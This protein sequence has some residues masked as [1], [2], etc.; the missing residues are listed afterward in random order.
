MST[1]S[2][3]TTTSTTSTSISLGSQEPLK[4]DSSF[5]NNFHRSYKMPASMKLPYTPSSLKSCYSMTDS[6]SSLASLMIARK[7]I[8]HRMNVRFAMATELPALSRQVSH[9]SDELLI[10]NTNNN[11]DRKRSQEQ[12]K[13]DYGYDEPTS[14]NGASS[15]QEPPFKRR[16]FQRRNSKTPAM[17]LSGL[18]DLISS[19]DFDGDNNNTSTQTQVTPPSSPL[20][21][22]A[23]DDGLQIAQDLVRQLQL[24]RQSNNSNN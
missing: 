1:S 14:K 3:E 24:R 7:Q 13:Y 12:D 21:S 9:S 4:D 11:N 2:I 15:L 5:M 8:L 17:L 10:N 23:G 20:L 19:Y 6:G 16:R 22:A 18:S